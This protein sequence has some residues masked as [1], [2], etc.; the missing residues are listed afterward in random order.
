MSQD[1][2]AHQGFKLILE[3]FAGSIR[4]QVLSRGMERRGIDPEDIIQEIRIRLWK[5]LSGEKK[6]VNPSSYIKK[7]VSS[8]L[9]DQL[10][11]SRAEQRLLC[12][13]MQKKLEEE[14]TQAN[15]DA[16]ENL[17]Q[18][19]EEAVDSLIESRRQVVKLFLLNLTAEEISKAL[20]LSH[21]KT[22]N[23]LYRG[24]QDLRIELKRRGV[25]YED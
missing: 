22:R 9:I 17:R 11:K 20:D 12:Q 5:R 1:K 13:A 6:V 7:V 8:V 24:L 18:T 15:R 14:K 2:T 25:S 19:L 10:R 21:D 4:A 3:K 23:L 16:E